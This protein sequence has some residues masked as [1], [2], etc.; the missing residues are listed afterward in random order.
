MLR[1]AVDEKT[2]N[3]VHLFAKVHAQRADGR[4]V[5]KAP[6]HGPPKSA[7]LD[8]DRLGPDVAA[9]HK[10]HAA[11]MAAQRKSQFR[12]D[13][14]HRPAADGEAIGSERAHL[15]AAP[16]SHAGGPAD[17]IPSEEWNPCL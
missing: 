4:G 5:P 10:A 8:V 17:E 1:N 11:Q 16:P 7:R 2:W 9:V 15:I 3:R 12:G 14:G 6:T 13:F